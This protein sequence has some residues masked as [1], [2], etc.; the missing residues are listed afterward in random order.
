VVDK[1]FSSG[2]YVMSS[3]WHYNPGEVFYDE[4]PPDHFR[5]AYSS[6]VSIFDIDDV[7]INF[8]YGI[9]ASADRP[10]EDIFI[11]SAHEG[12]FKDITH[13]DL[14]SKS[15]HHL[16]SSEPDL[17]PGYHLYKTINDIVTEKYAVYSTIYR[18]K[19][20]WL[21]GIAYDFKYS[22]KITIPRQLFINDHG[23]ISFVLNIHK[24]GSKMYFC[25]LSRIYYR[26]LDDDKIYLE[27]DSRYYDHKE[28]EYQSQLIEDLRSSIE[29]G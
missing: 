15:Y 12:K 19:N 11:D 6:D 18:K 21:L 20:G 10:F 8:Y 1:P 17:K 3:D 4:K 9:C 22:E 2:L 23:V 29:S 24:T 7:T 28:D 26:M 27:T 16:H 13:V 14:E 25:S 5:V